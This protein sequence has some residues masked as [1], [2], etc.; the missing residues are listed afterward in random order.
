ML[1]LSHVARLSVVYH[2]AGFVCFLFLR[3]MMYRYLSTVGESKL[4]LIS[5]LYGVVLF[6]PG[7]CKLKLIVVSGLYVNCCLNLSSV[8]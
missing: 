2:F 6:E 8:N 4:M 1:S 5:K 7:F 3:C